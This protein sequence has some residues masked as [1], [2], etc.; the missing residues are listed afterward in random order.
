MRLG[1]LSTYGTLAALALALGTIAPA[2]AAVSVDIA[3]DSSFSVTA[4]AKTSHSSVKK[5]STRLK[6]TATLKYEAYVLG[7]AMPVTG[8][9]MN[10]FPTV[11]KQPR[12]DAANADLASKSYRKINNAWLGTKQWVINGQQGFW[13]TKTV[14]LKGSAVGAS[15]GSRYFHA[16]TGTGHGTDANAILRVTVK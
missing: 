6:G 1:R 5:N 15:K 11:F 12:L 10:S 7:F 8:Y 16:G 13:G 3:G 2:Q 14:T 4:T 9:Y